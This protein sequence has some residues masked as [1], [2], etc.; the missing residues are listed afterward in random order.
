[1][2]ASAT[3][4]NKSNS[5]IQSAEAIFNSS[6][7]L[8]NSLNRANTDVLISSDDI[9]EYEN[10]LSEMKES[11]NYMNKRMKLMEECKLSY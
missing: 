10:Y 3:K 1:M 5:S 8:M 2:R 11:L 9:I 4:S 6:G 7:N